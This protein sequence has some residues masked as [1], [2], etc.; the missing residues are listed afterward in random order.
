MRQ[1]PPDWP[2]LPSRGDPSFFLWL[3]LELKARVKDPSRPTVLCLHRDQFASDLRELCRT[4]ERF[5]YSILEV[6][7]LNYMQSGLI[8][9][10]LPRQESFYTIPEYDEQRAAV[11]EVG[12]RLLITL[13]QHLNLVGIMAANWDYWTDL[14]L[15]Y[16]AKRLSI[17]FLILNRENYILSREI[18]EA[19]DFFR[20][21]YL[22]RPDVD[23]VAV[24]GNLTRDVF[25][26]SHVVDPSLIHTTGLPRYD[27]WIDV[28]KQPLD[29][30]A[31]NEITLITYTDASYGGGDQFPQMLAQFVA[32]AARHRD[33]PVR[34]VVKVKHLFDLDEINKL[35]AAFPDHGVVL[36]SEPIVQA[37]QRSRAV[38]G[39]NSMALVEALL[40]GANVYVPQ[41]GATKIGQKDQFFW[42]EDPEH[43]RHVTFLE[44]PEHFAQ[45]M[46]AEV[47]GT[48][49]RHDD[50]REKVALFQQF[51][52]F[53][54]DVSATTKV[55][56]FIARSIADYWTRTIQQGNAPSTV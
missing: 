10:H 22:F 33:T 3:A 29:W 31:R 32:L 18:D 55:E 12:M 40:S 51:L 48:A 7:V 25:V 34:F 56:D 42:R 53:D 30:S 39:Y 43:R 20:K 21:E 52:A 28:L 17:P 2:I 49:P 13:G 4:G 50:R 26:T 16:A 14:G 45:L 41:W 23:G 9:Q 8:P 15:R 1:L 19:P 11:T 38:I 47:A 5:S 35:L 27:P 6:S 36:S 37:L 46:D 54:P 24:G 44:S